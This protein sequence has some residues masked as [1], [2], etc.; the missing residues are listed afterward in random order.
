MSISDDVTE[1]EKWQKNCPILTAQ[2][3]KSIEICLEIMVVTMRSRNF[4]HENRP[5][6]VD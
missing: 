5:T 2:P 4:F 6:Y 3:L 1:I